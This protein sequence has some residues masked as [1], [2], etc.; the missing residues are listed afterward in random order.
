MSWKKTA[1]V[2]CANRCGLEVRVENNRIVKVRGDRD[3]PFSKGY[4]CRKGLN[5]AFHQHNRDRVLFPMKKAGDRFER[6]SWDQAIN[7]IS[8]KL[9]A[10]VDTHGPR[11]LASLVGGGEFS[12]L[13]ASFPVRLVRRLGSR[14]NYSA[15]N[16]EFSG[17]YWAHGLAFG[18]QNIQMESDFENCD[19]LMLIGKNPMMSHHFHQARRRLP[20]MSRDPDR[21]LVVVDPRLS[22]TAQ[23]ADV[24]LAPRP[25]T[26]ALLLKSMISIILDEGLYHKDYVDRHAAGFDKILPCFAGFD[27]KAALKVCELDYHKV[28]EVCRELASRRSSILDDLGILMNRHSALVSFLVVVLLALCG[29]IGVP[30][31]NYMHGGGRGPGPG[32]RRAWKTLKTGIPAINGMFPPNVLPEEI[33]NDHPERLRA[34]LCYAANPLRSYADT[35]AYEN[36]FQKLDLLVT[37]EIAMS[38]TAAL[39]DYVLPC[40]TYYECWDGF[41]GEGISEIYARMTPPVIEPEGEQKE[42]AEIYTLLADAMGVIPPIPDSLYASARSGDLAAYGRDLAAYLKANPQSGK[43][44]NFIIAKTLGPALGSAHLA[45]IFPAFM[46]LSETRRQEAQKA[47][48][49]MGPQ[50]GIDIYRA[51]MSHPEGIRIGIRDPEKNMEANIAT[52]NGKIR[53][54]HPEVD[55]WIRKIDPDEENRRLKTGK[56]FPLVLMAGRHW[57]MNANT[58]MR[59]PSWNRGKRACTL[60]INPSDAQALGIADKQ[61]VRVVTEA[62][63]EQIEAEVTGDARKGQVIIPHGFGLVYDGVAYGVNVNRLTKNTN[64]DFVGTPMHRYV[65]CRVEAI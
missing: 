4:V 21:L 43:A 13:S 6:I 56:N 9:K 34:V 17:R 3:S 19:M 57:D 28:L 54:Y 61:L 36:A 2:L 51:V 40:K 48:F 27:V 41:A 20:K 44:L 12:F 10:I 23:I 11:S 24:H 14:W 55:A 52:G 16:Q 38:E 32:D 25:G 31:G 60:A 46:Q 7:E 59:D 47:G 15:A 58:A 30:G 49:P 18:N 37:A 26:D 53:L 64:R 22:E 42:N 5:V 29:R 39:A 50:Q 8:G 63:A 1:C 65:P 33:L 45:S 35:T 62:G